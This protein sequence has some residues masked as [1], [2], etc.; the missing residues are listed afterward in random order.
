MSRWTYTDD[1][2]QN[3]IASAKD[4]IVQDLVAI[5]FCY[6]DDSGGVSE[7]HFKEIEKLIAE[8]NKKEQQ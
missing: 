5:I 6:A 2:Q 8:S 3:L 7:Y 4:P 1:D